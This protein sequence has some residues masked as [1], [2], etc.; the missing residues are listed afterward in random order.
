M[1]A[2]PQSIRA[3]GP[4]DVRGIDHVRGL[5]RAYAAEFADAVAE[6]LCL[7]GFEAELAGLPGRYSPPSGCLL[8]AADGD[9]PAGCVALRDLGD[10]TCEMKRL[11]VAPE[12][13]GR[14]VGQL[15]VAEIVRRGARAGCRRMVL[16][17]VPEMVAALALY[18]R[19]GFVP[20]G[21]Y[22]ASPVERTIFLERTLDAVALSGGE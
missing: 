17:T 20:T 7:Q 10:G 12:H 9:R 1:S 4:D 8:L 13:R 2:G 22:H 16:D 6:S 19:H 18:E 21:A 11:Y 3:V 5:L 15:L 14:R